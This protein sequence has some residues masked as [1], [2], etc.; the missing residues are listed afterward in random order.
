MATGATTTDDA[1]WM[2]AA[3]TEAEHGVGL[4]SPNPPV[5]A[6]VVKDGRLLGSGYHRITG[7]PHA[8]I[9]ALQA[10]ISSHG[11]DTVKGATLYITLEPCSTHGRTPPCCD[12][13][14]EAG[15]ARVVYGSTDPNPAH[16]GRA[17]SLLAG[18]GITVLSGAC[19]D[20]AARLI[21]PFSKRVR[22]GLPWVIIKAGTSWDGKI[23]RPTGEPQWL[24]SEDAREDAH[25]LRATADA[26]IVGAETVRLDNPSLT[27]RG[28]A[29]RTG[30]PQPW[31]VVL[32]RSNEL[33]ENVRLLTDEHRE[34]TLVFQNRPL[35]EVLQKLAGHGC[36]TVLVEGGGEI[37]G[38]FFKNS[39]ADEIVLYLAPLWC[40]NGTKPTSGSSPLPA[41]VSLTEV[42]VRK[43]G[44]NVRLHAIIKK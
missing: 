1:R 19:P 12:A 33:P 36:N 2:Q 22:T 7:G 39:L 18:A 31:R 15:I 37:L 24:T 3:L 41:S 35:I 4:T 9:V 30:K 21:R 43:I 14:I 42:D 27:I 16:T 38:Q 6:A 13:I 17:D 10:A 44:D 28:A 40:G 5:G 26:I 20:G 11:K 8:E 29:H 32:T 34:R 23:T 25:R